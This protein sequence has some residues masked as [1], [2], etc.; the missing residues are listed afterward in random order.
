MDVLFTF[1]EGDDVQLIL[2]IILYAKFMKKQVAVVDV[3][4][5]FEAISSIL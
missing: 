1:L 2:L 5:F 4:A 3:D